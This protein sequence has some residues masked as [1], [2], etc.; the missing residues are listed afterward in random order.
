MIAHSKHIERA[1]G[2][3]TADFGV[4]SAALAVFNAALED[5]HRIGL[6]ELS[7]R[8][9]RLSRRQILDALLYLASERAGVM[10]ASVLLDGEMTPL[11]SLWSMLDPG[12]ADIRE[13]AALVFRLA[14][15]FE[16]ESR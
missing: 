4:G 15:V 16:R 7:D 10:V 13:R 14:P 1:I 8:L 11:S 2:V 3:I 6:D 9:P 5:A 12:S